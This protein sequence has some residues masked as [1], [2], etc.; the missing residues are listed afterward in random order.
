MTFFDR[1]TL[2]DHGFLVDYEAKKVRFFHPSKEKYNKWTFSDFGTAFLTSFLYFFILFYLPSL[3]VL[4]LASLITHFTV[5]PQIGIIILGI[6]SL[7]S[8]IWAIVMSVNR[9]MRRFSID[10]F[11]L[12]KAN[13]T[14]GV[15]EIMIT[16]DD[17]FDNT[18]IL[19]NIQGDGVLWKWMGDFELYKQ[20][21]E[22]KPVKTKVTHYGIIKSEDYRWSLIFN[23]KEKPKIGYLF[24]RIV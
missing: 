5:S 22:L 23:F 9:K 20:N 10:L 24:I 21:I 19:H 14:Y 3:I 16:P 11:S 15:E 12:V 2:E 7:L 13:V 4:F 18:F 1:D 17:I 6:T 8:F